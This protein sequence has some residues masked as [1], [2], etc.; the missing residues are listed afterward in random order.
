MKLRKMA[1]LSMCIVLSALALGGCGQQKQAA[2]TI[3]QKTETAEVKTEGSTDAA[4]TESKEGKKLY[5]PIVSKGWQH[6][7]WQAVKMGADQAAADF[8][9]EITFEGPEGDAAVDKQI[10]MIEA[11]LMKK[12]DALI[13]AACDSR[14]VVPQ[15]EKAKAAGIPVI[16]FDSGIES[17]IPLTTAAT[18]NAEAAALAADKMAE[19]INLEGE[20]ALVVHDQ[21]SVTGTARRDGFV[22]RIKEKYPKINIVDIQYGGGDHLKS[23]DVTKALIQGHPNLKGIFG[24]NE[25]SAVGV[26]NGVTESDRIGKIVVI[27]YDAGKLQKDA[28]RNGVMLGAI[29]QDPVGIGYKAVEA[30]FKAAN[31]ETLPKLID[32][33]FKWYD[34]SNVDSEEMKP[35]LYD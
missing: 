4:K 1:S 17:D 31:G 23:T 18:D 19:A 5:L 28:I 13:L 16:G 27:G 29:T 34:K 3:T 8:G 20:V 9:V 15:L 14:A 2:E 21:A 32:T 26:I 30:A 25:G 33:G 24:A 22:N 11:A 10:E 6:Q 7:F 12:P 35:L